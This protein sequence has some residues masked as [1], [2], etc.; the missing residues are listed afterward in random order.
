[1]SYVTLPLMPHTH[2]CNILLVSLHQSYSRWQR[3]I[4]GHEY[5]EVDSLGALTAAVYLYGYR[6]YL[7][8][9]GILISSH[10]TAW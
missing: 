10:F 4:Q 3:P 2:F 6:I 5:R 1:M 7:I 9:E 8:E